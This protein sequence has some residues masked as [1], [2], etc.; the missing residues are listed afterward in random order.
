MPASLSDKSPE[1]GSMAPQRPPEWQSYNAV[2][3]LSDL[4]VYTA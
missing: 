1:Q 4:V 2:A 3:F